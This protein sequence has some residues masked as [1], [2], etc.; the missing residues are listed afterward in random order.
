MPRAPIGPRELEAELEIS[1]I[2]FARVVKFSAVALLDK[3][4][5][6]QY[7]DTGRCITTTM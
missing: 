5:T 7:C 6:R 3:E 1:A 4:L 2:L